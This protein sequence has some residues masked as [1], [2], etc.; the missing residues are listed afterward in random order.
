MVRT[1]PESGEKVLC[2]NQEFT[3]H[4][5]NFH[6]KRERGFGADFAIAANHLLDYLFPQVTIP[7]FQFRLRWQANTFAF[8]DNRSTQH[9][10]VQDY[11][12]AT[13]RMARATIVGNQPF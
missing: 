1:H 7:E 13:R 12:P 10:A 11:A 8:W 4:F 3:T 5:S 6:G 2:V 9:Y